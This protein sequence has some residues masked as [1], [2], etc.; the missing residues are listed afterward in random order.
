MQL[1]FQGTTKQCIKDLE[2]S[3]ADPKF[4]G[5]EFTFSSNHWSTMGTMK[6]LIINVVVPWCVFYPRCSLCLQPTKWNLQGM[7]WNIEEAGVAGVGEK[8]TGCLSA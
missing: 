7:I 8:G 2:D 5:W 1:V 3:R 4:A 6:T